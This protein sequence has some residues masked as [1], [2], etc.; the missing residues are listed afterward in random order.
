M[1]QE[2]QAGKSSSLYRCFHKF[3]VYYTILSE[4]LHSIQ[5]LRKVRAQIL[6]GLNAARDPH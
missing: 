3:S 6:G 4:A 5:R 2:T 1:G